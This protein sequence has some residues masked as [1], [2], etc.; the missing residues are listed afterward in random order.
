MYQSLPLQDPP[1]FT[2]IGIF[3]LKI[4]TISG[5]PGE[6]AKKVISSTQIFFDNCDV[7]N[8]SSVLRFSGL[9]DGMFSNMGEFWRAL[10]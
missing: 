4:Y 3:G 8:L 7:T 10:E 1:N 2:Q 6:S 5:N 9:P